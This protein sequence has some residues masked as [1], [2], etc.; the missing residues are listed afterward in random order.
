[1]I[2]WLNVAA[3]SLWIVGC[4]IALAALSRASWQSTI[5]QVKL[6]AI[7]GRSGYQ[8]A[9]TIAGSLFCLG[10]AGAAQSALKIILWLALAIGFAGLAIAV[11]VRSGKSG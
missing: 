7:L 1:V 8:I 6:G 3:N 2:D 10:G 4:A 5:Q 9:L 11:K